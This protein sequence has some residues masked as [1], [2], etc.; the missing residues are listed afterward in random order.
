MGKKLH[1]LRKPARQPGRRNGIGNGQAAA[2]KQQY[3][4]G[5]MFGLFPGEQKFPVR[6]VRRNDKHEHTEENR[7]GGIGNKGQEFC[8]KRLKNPAQRGGGKQK[9]HL[10][11]VFAP[12][13]EFV[14]FFDQNMH[15]ACL[16]Q[17]NF[18]SAAG[19]PPKT[20][21]QKQQGNGHA[22]KHPLPKAY[23]NIVMFF[24]KTRAAGRWAGFR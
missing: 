18:K 2:E 17:R 6:I 21:Q 23:V 15:G 1:L 22:E 16:V 12:G 24:Q 13:T 14:Y 20:Q 19:Q 8:Q 11:F 10:F 4:P 3:A 9:Q 7:N 5:N